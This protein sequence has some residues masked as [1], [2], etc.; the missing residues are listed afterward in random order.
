MSSRIMTMNSNNQQ[1]RPSSSAPGIN[2]PP[3]STTPDEIFSKHFRDITLSDGPIRIYDYG[4]QNADATRTCTPIFLLHGAMLDTAPFTWRHLLPSLSAHRRVLAIDL[5]RHGASRPWPASSDLDQRALESIVTS[6]LDSLSLDR[7]ILIGLSMGAGLAIGYTINNPS[8]VSSLVA[9]NPGGLDYTRP[10]Q[11]PTYLMTRCG[12]L[13][14]WT[15]RHLASSPSMLRYSI[16]QNLVAGEQTRD[17]DALMALVETE[18]KESARHDEAALDDWQIAAYGPWG[19]KVN[20]TPRLEGLGVP[21]LWVHGQKDKMVTE[22]SMR[23]AAEMAP[24]GRF[25]SISDAAHM[26]P[27]DQP[28]SVRDAIVE[29]LDEV[30]G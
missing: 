5:P 17:F 8:R 6:V 22:G 3:P 2:P 29:F 26:A 28:E 19:M 1:I 7:T 18:A 13:L 25:V 9:I 24:G 15:T 23:R 20:F 16:A 12:P 10:A 21:S 14:R 27:L 30:E 4:P 11:F